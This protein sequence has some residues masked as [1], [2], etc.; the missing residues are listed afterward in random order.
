MVEFLK[1][2]TDWMLEK[3]SELANKCAIDSKDIEKQI[4]KMEEKKA[5]LE[6]ECEENRKELE[7][8]LA[9]LRWIEAETLKCSK[10]K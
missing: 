5:Q 10:D 3:E 2:M 7:H 1:K 6:K 9:R 4:S 8:I